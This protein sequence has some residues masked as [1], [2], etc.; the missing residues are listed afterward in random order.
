MATEV[1]MKLYPAASVYGCTFVVDVVSP[2]IDLIL[3]I[4]PYIIKNWVQL[5]QSCYPMRYRMIAIFNA[6]TIFDVIVKIAKSF[7]TEKLRNR[8]HVSSHMPHYFNDIPPDA[9]P[10]EYGGTGET[11]QE[12]TGNYDKLEGNKCDAFS[13]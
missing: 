1:A 11:C 3:Q 13:G 10:V 8:F 9:L 2:S 12:L 5:W 4:R 7:M 6:P